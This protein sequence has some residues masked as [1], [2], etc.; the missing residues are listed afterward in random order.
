MNAT[1]PDK[2]IDARRLRARTTDRHQPPLRDTTPPARRDRP[3]RRD[4]GS[5]TPPHG[6]AV[7]PHSHRHRP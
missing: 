3:A 7:L 6:D 5:H 2:S 4:D 1:A